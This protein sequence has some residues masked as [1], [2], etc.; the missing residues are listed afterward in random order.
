MGDDPAL[1]YNSM[2]I[3]ATMP[4]MTMDW[5][6]WREMLQA[7]EERQEYQLRMFRQRH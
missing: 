3:F 4:E 7:S 5:S 6:F 1:G 2:Q